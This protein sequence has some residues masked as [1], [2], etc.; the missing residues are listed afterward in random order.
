MA[1]PEATE[2]TLIH[3]V[4]VAAIGN[5][6]RLLKLSPW[7]S[8]SAVFLHLGKMVFGDLIP[9]QEKFRYMLVLI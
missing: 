6:S 8:N 4:S 9:P 3:L 7:H 1:K 5:T 2:L